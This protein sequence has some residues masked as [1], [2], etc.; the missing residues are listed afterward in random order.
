VAPAVRV[1]RDGVPLVFARGTLNVQL[2]IRS[3]SWSD[4]VPYEARRP[5]QLESV[6]GPLR[7][8][9]SALSFGGR[10]AEICD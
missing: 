6:A 3:G 2:G 7:V 4:P 1:V 8:R 9:V 10:M 5:E